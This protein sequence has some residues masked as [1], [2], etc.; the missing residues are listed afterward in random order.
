MNC[1]NG[2]RTFP[3]LVGKLGHLR[4][5]K[6]SD[7]KITVVGSGKSLGICGTGKGIDSLRRAIRSDSMDN[8]MNVTR[9]H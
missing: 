9:A 6:C 2:G 7:T 1:V 4:C 3:V 5:H 8:R